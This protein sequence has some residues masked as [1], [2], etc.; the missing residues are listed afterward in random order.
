MRKPGFG[1]IT[2]VITILVI[3][4]FAS[5]IFSSFIPS[6]AENRL[7][8]EASPFLVQ[9]GYQPIDW[10]LPGEDTF[11][12]ARRLDRLIMLVVGSACSRT[13]RDV[14]SLAFSAPE[15]R[16]A[17]ATNF[18]PVRVDVMENPEYGAAFLPLSRAFKTGKD[19]LAIPSD[20][21]IWIFSPDGKLI[22]FVAQ[23]DA[24]RPLDAR[25]ILA[26]LNFAVEQFNRKDA[27]IEPGAGQLA[28]LNLLRGP[29]TP[30]GVDAFRYLSSLEPMKD[31]SYGGYPQNGFQRLWPYVW[32]LGVLNRFNISTQ[33]NPLL[34]SPTTDVLDGGFF[35][36]SASPDW[37]H[38]Q[39]D[40]YSA[41]NAS[42]LLTL[43]LAGAIDN[44]R[45]YSYLARRTFDFL[46]NSMFQN[47]SITGGQIG[48]ESGLD[49][50]KRSSFSPKRLR[51]LVEDADVREK[52][53]NAFGL[54]V[55]S[56]PQMTPRYPDFALAMDEPETFDRL[57]ALLERERPEAKLTGY[58][59]LD[60]SGFCIARML[61]SARILGDESRLKIA[62]EI[63]QG[64][65]SFR[66]GDAVAHSIGSDRNVASYLGDYLGYADAA[67]QYFLSTGDHLAFE[68]GLAVLQRGLFLF[69][70]PVSGEFDI[71]QD[72]EGV[73]GIQNMA[74][75]EICDGLREACTSQV[76]R[77]TNAYGR[78]L[79][80]SGKEMMK[81][82][83]DCIA[84]YSPFVENLGPYAG[85]FYCALSEFNALQHCIVVGPDSL[86]QAIQLAP[87]APNALISPVNGKVKAPGQKPGFYVVTDT[88]STGPLTL[89]QAAKTLNGG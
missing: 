5:R 6:E 55:E 78:L 89:A 68:H 23:L 2:S 69:A 71:T 48:D 75:P 79:G 82:S 12:E 44:E 50:S 30:S 8:F 37:L 35:T 34:H 31:P 52:V 4:A 84:R 10:R 72:L 22:T 28:D 65:D 40:K 32:R 46:A 19:R 62:K 74:V 1:V 70:G 43:S 56:N 45:S 3:I 60:I 66:T 33:I 38:V 42:M 14:D 13:G 73:P 67:L 86:A 21:Q 59:E 29:V 16:S 57:K 54:R 27:R 80:Q 58:S 7:A 49:R 18:V 76:I 85:S 61:Q 47:G 36:V 63:F 64:L 25:L 83:G 51:D 53:R 24:S 11:R 87:L 20:F 26:Q 39:Y 81:I 88:S 9:A 17:I 41:E 77:L 15:V